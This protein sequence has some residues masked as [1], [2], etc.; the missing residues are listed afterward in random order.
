MPVIDAAVDIFT[1][2]QCYQEIQDKFVSFSMPQFV[3]EEATPP[4]G[5]YHLKAT[6]CPVHNEHNGCSTME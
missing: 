3:L 5:D 2:G 1:L 4:Q 6:H